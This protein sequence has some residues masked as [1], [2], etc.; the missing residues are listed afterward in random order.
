MLSLHLIHQIAAIF[1][2]GVKVF[3]TKSCFPHYLF[4]SYLSFALQLHTGGYNDEEKEDIDSII[5]VWFD[6]A[7]IAHELEGA[8]RLF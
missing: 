5:Q 1:F 6:S 8:K 4:T 3:L 2:E 7:G